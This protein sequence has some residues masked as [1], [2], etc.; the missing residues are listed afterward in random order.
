MRSRWRTLKFH[1]KS[2]YIGL[3]AARGE[4]DLKSTSAKSLS[5]LFFIATAF[6]CILAGVLPATFVSTCF[7][8]LGAGAPFVSAAWPTMSGTAGIAGFLLLMLGISATRFSNGVYDA[9]IRAADGIDRWDQAFHKET[10]GFWGVQPSLLF[11]WVSLCATSVF[12]IYWPSIQN[13]FF[14]Y[15]DFE[16]LSYYKNYPLLKSLAV[17]HG[18]HV[19]PL[20]RLE[21]AVMYLLFGVNHVPYNIALVALFCLT[22]IFPVLVLRELK[23]GQL[24]AL[25]FLVLY[26]GW[27]EWGLSLTGYYCLSAYLQTA[28]FCTMAIWSFLRWKHTPKGC[29]PKIFAMSLVLAVAVD[30][31][32]VF[33]PVTVGTFLVADYFATSPLRIHEWLRVHRRFIRSLLVV[34]VAYA[35]FLL[36]AFT[37]VNPNSFL[38]MKAINIAK[39]AH[40][41]PSDLLQ[42][43]FFVTNGLALSAFFSC[44]NAL[45]IR[46]L[47]LINVAT[48][49]VM[50]SLAC[51]LYKSEIH[52]SYKIRCLGIFAIILVFGVMVVKGRQS[53]GVN[54]VWSAKYS[55]PAFTWFCVL[56]AYYWDTVWKF[57]GRAF[58]PLLLQAATVLTI[59]ILVLRAPFIFENI[60]LLSYPF[61]IS[62]AINR[63]TAVSELRDKLVKPLLATVSEVS[64]PTLDGTFINSRYE[65]L[66]VFNLS[67]YLDFVVP[68]GKKL[69]L[70]R[71]QQMHEWGK[72]R[73]TTVAD[74]RNHTSSSFME[75]LNRPGFLQH[76]YTRPYPL[77]YKD[78]SS[79]C[80]PNAP[81]NGRISDAR[82]VATLKDGSLLITSDGLA[83]IRVTDGRWDPQERHVLVVDITA[84]GPL[85]E[86]PALGIS[87]VG[88]MNIPRSIY[89]LQLDQSQGGKD[90]DLL[91]LPAYSLNAK[92]GEIELHFTQPG[93][94]VL[95]T[96]AFH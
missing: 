90:I 76:M 2:A 41:D 55:G 79:N 8:Y 51:Y 71:N 60:G 37:V 84:V 39:G 87:F 45:P 32:G 50:A 66:F 91:Q 92:V 88:Q 1:L 52:R 69:V 65:R 29:Y 42:L 26:T 21:V 62:D 19:L 75:A 16:F 89:E 33:V 86:Q 93:Q 78:G 96:A 36:Y 5:D 27:T 94:Y 95:R 12:F 3:T 46:L 48:L 54:S 10:N 74:L 83:R 7:E 44:Y 34:C 73:I 4:N 24:G 80:T 59:A 30:L 25:L 28:L 22:A 64:I 82:S 77:I 49:S 15:D 6:C 68:E 57:T 70:Y 35:A 11:L 40:H 85:L 81:E 47:L 63:R 23:V 53:S 17:V 31:S 56:L 38:S 67:H 9:A 61:L 14:R 58:R 20:Y 72:D 13:G 43:Y 18:D